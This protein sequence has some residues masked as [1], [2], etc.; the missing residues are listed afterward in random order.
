MIS[1]FR[2]VCFN[3]NIGKHKLFNSVKPFLNGGFYKCFAS[4]GK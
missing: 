4:D 1:I 3:K 2:I